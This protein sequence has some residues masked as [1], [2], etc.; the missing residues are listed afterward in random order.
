MQEIILN[1]LDM[2]KVVLPHV[3][4]ILLQSRNKHILI[5]TQIYNTHLEDGVVLPNIML[6]TICLIT[7]IKRREL[8]HQIMES[9][10]SVLIRKLP[11][12]SAQE[13]SG[14]D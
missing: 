12:V 14:L 6:M 5:D 11:H 13:L 8:Q 2:N 7:G 1:K 9:H 10:F 3:L 4:Q